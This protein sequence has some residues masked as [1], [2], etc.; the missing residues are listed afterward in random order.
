MT[1]LE[2]AIQLEKDMSLDSS[3]Q[4]EFLKL[5]KPLGFRSIESYKKRKRNFLF[6]SWIPDTYSVPAQELQQILS[7]ATLNNSYGI[8]IPSL[9]NAK[10]FHTNESINYDSCNNLEIPIIEMYYTG[11]TAVVGKNDLYIFIISPYIMNLD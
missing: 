1:N 10:L 2:Q 4:K 6:N 7:Q 8:Y 11:T 9:D 3:N 5:I